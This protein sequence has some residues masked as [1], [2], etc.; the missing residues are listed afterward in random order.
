LGQVLVVLEKEK[1]MFQREPSETYHCPNCGRELKQER[2]EL[3]CSEH[4]AFFAY[5]PQLL[6]RAP[7]GE[8]RSSKTPMPWEMVNKR[9]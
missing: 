9:A 4:G 3:R 8:E 6:V 1:S 7:E 2:G 5:G